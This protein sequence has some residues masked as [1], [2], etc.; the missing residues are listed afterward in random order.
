MWVGGWVGQPKSRGANLTPP[1]VSLSKGLVLREWLYRVTR[2][3][4]PL[5]P[6]VPL[7]LPRLPGAPLPRL[8]PSA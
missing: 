1:P 3:A 6:H 2:L 5:P 7:V 8:P 4:Y